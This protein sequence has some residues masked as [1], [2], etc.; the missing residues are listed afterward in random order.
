[1]GGCCSKRTQPKL[2]K[3]K[4]ELEINVL[5][6][7]PQGRPPPIRIPKTIVHFSNTESNSPKYRAKNIKRKKKINTR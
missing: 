7:T 2:E 5:I 1:M 4:S 6:D 3:K